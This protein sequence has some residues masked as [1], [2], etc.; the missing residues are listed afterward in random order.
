VKAAALLPKLS[1]IRTKRMVGAVLLPPARREQM[2]LEGGM[3]INPLEP[4]DQ[5]DMWINVLQSARGEQTLDDADVACAHFRPAK[6]PIFTAQGQRANLPP[7]VIGIQRDGG[8][9]QKD[10]QRRA[11]G[12]RLVGRLPKRVGG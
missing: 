2:D 5:I 12:E 10:T 1:K 4:I 8:I 11:A 7:Q 6:Q 9:G 3:G